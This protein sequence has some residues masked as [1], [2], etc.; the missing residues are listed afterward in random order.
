MKK[1]IVIIFFSLMATSILAQDMCYKQ[2]KSLIPERR[3]NIDSLFFLSTNT[4]GYIGCHSNY[5][6][7]L[8]SVDKG[9][10]CNDFRIKFDTLEFNFEFNNEN[11]RIHLNQRTSYDALGFNLESYYS[12]GKIREKGYFMKNTYTQ[13]GV[14]RNSAIEC[15]NFT[16]D[17]LIWNYR[18]LD[19]QGNGVLIQYDLNGNVSSISRFENYI[20]VEDQLPNKN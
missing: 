5:I 20:L 2:M 8:W 15:T 10:P 19:P 14:W 6:N 7:F 3:S 1:C 4:K 18:K 17:G 16:E 9:F 12:S 11:G 13:G